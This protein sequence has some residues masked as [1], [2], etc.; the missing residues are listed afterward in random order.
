MTNADA[1]RLRTARSDDIPR[2]I[3]VQRRASF[4]WETY[5]DALVAHPEAIDVP[6][7]QVQAGNV[8]VVTDDDDVPVGFSAIIIRGERVELDGL[9][10]APEWMRRGLGGALVADVVTRAR[11]AGA[12]RVEVVANPGAVPFYERHGFRQTGT[13]ETRFGPAPRFTLELGGDDDD[14]GKDDARG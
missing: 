7:E 4:I 1:N 10:V 13:T 2:L 8:R 3:D 9:F 14:D 5:R 12:R 11:S 6:A